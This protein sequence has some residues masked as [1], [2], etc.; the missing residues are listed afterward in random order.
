MTE[1]QPANLTDATGDEEVVHYQSSRQKRG[2]DQGSKQLNLTS[3]IDVIFLLLIYFVVTAAFTQGEGVISAKLPQGSGAPAED[4]KP[5]ERKLIVMLN[6]LA[7]SDTRIEIKD[8][9]AVGDFAELQTRLTSLRHDELS[10]PNGTYP[11]DSPV[12]IQPEG[13][14]RWQHVVNAF[15]AAV[16][17][18]F[19]NVSFSEAGAE[20]G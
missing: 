1:Q 18:R 5:P 16:A 4:L 12:L 7:A 20:D 11:T 2:R 8:L 13:S 14:V 10:N 15:N 3:M 6:P 17:S 9:Y 19:T